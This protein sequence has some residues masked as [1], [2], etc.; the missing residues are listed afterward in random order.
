[1]GLFNPGVGTYQWPKEIKAAGA[2]LWKL[3]KN[4][5]SSDHLI[6]NAD[7][8][9]LFLRDGK[10]YGILDEGEHTLTSANVPF[11]GGLM[12]IGTGRKFVGEIYY[13]WM[14]EFTD[15]KFGTTEPMVFKDPDFGLVRI[16]AF[17]TYSYQVVDPQVFITKFVGTLNMATS[18]QIVGWLKGQLV[19]AL[20]DALGELKAKGL[21]IVDFPAQLDEISSI[22]LSKVRD[23]LKPYGVEV[24]R[25]GELNINLP[26]EV[27]KAVDQRSTMGA[28]GLNDPGMRNA[29]M[30]M[31]SGKMMEGAGQGMAKGGE[32][33]GMAGMGAGLGVGMMMPQ[34]MQQNMMQNQQQ[35]AQKQCAKCGTLNTLSTKFCANCGAPFTAPGG[36]CPKCN[37]DVPAGTK[38]CPECGT[39]V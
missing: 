13:V 37:A 15:Q 10:I 38:F 17:G 20:N 22:L 32:G 2:I 39:K 24:M 16:R 5:V 29:Y 21:T 18:D 26:E 9:A 30:T 4:I 35:Q 7:E 27:Q 8:K 33:A 31:Q 36:K 12:E 23:D 28:L 34:M 25:I 3:N 14:K 19:R 6:V 1:M 11:L